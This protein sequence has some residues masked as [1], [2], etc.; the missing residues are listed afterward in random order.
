MQTVMKK[1]SKK[2]P[3]MKTKKLTTPMKKADKTKATKKADN[4]NTPGH[5]QKTCVTLKQWSCTQMDA[6][7]FGKLCGLSWDA[8]NGTVEE[9]WQWK[10]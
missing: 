4:T 9:K 2:Q 3:P 10:Q 6:G 8:R 1:P 7:W 5:G